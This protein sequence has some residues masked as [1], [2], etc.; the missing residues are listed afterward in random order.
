MCASQS[1]VT[2]RVRQP[3]TVLHVAR[4][5]AITKPRLIS[6]ERHCILKVRTP[7]DGT[8]LRRRCGV[9]FVAIADRHC[10]GIR[11]TK[12]GPPSPWASSMR[13]RTLPC[14]CTSLSLKKVTI[15][16]SLTD[17]RKTFGEATQACQT[18][19]MYRRIRRDNSCCEFCRKAE[20]S[21]LYPGLGAY[22]Q[23]G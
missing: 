18:A 4:P 14:R 23:V 15:T 16:K 17:C 11:S 19:F 2:C 8:I 10:F 22:A 7:S 3:A 6:P 5:P 20:I 12:I 9:A 13:R 1:K 21:P